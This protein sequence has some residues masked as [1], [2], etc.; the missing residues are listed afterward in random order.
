MR[1]GEI[2]IQR[3]LIT[4]EDLERALEL[5]KERGDK[6]GKILIDLGVIASALTVHSA[7]APVPSFCAAVISLFGSTEWIALAT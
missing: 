1:L 7:L 4:E 5:Q 3:K 2:L 6:L